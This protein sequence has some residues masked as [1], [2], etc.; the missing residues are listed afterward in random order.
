MG[1]RRVGP[2]RVGPEGW[3]PEGWGPEP[4][5][6]G[7]RR[8]GARKVGGLSPARNFILSSLSGGSSCGI[9]VVF[10]VLGPS[11]VR[12]WSSLVVV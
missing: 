12:V 4:R 9:L 11:N 3:G 5:K 8:L 6:G 1:P 10:E 7:A 2:R